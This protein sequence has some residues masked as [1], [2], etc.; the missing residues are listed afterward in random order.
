MKLNVAERVY[1]REIQCLSDKSVLDKGVV[2][3][4]LVLKALK[5]HLPTRVPKS[6]I[7]IF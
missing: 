7:T 2:G 5:L 4:G 6:P 3:A 1:Y